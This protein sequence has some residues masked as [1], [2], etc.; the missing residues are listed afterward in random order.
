MPII[1]AE[2]TRRR[3]RLRHYAA[4]NAELINAGRCAAQK[5]KTD[6]IRRYFTHFW[7]QIH[8]IALK[9][10]GADDADNVIEV[11]KFLNVLQ[12]DKYLKLSEWLSSASALTTNL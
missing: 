10:Y 5:L 9:I 6:A 1:S 11:T 2:M 3:L 7:R 8:E 12:G 4:I